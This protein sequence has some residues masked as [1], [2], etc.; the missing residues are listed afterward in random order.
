MGGGG[1]GLV[2]FAERIVEIKVS[3]FR[4]GDSVCEDCRIA[5]V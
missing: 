5:G 4:E 3:C 1:D 2:G